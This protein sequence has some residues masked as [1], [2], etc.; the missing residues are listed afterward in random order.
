MINILIVFAL[1]RLF[2]VYV[3]LIYCR[4]PNLPNCLADFSNV[5]LKLLKLL[6]FGTNLIG[7]IMIIVW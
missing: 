2:S 6:K 1:C 3:R 5:K 7:T 4:L